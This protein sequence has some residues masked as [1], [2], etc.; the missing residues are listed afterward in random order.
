[1]AQG[2]GRSPFQIT[3][4]A[5]ERRLL[6]N[7][8]RPGTAEH[9]QVTRVRIILLAAAGWT[10]RG[11]ARKLGLAPNTAGKWRQRCC[12]E[13]LDGLGDRKRAGR[14]RTFPA[15]VIAAAKAIACE[16]PATRGVPLAAGALPSSAP[17]SSPPA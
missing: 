11:I 9:P 17:R 15:A 2:G 14:P 5:S 1:V 12:Q 7:L 8:T 16:L 6:K 3:L 4:P 10:N 13:G